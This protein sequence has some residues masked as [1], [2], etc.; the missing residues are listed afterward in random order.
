MGRRANPPEPTSS[1]VEPWAVSRCRTRAVEVVA[2]GERTDGGAAGAALRAKRMRLVY[3]AAIAA[4]LIALGFTTERWVRRRHR[5]SVT[6]QLSQALSTYAE[7]ALGLPLAPGE[8][9]AA[10]L[11]RIEAGLPEPAIGPAPMATEDAWPLR[12]RVDLDR[13]HALIS[14][15]PRFAREPAAARLDTLI[16]RARLDPMPT[17]AVDLLDTLLGAAPLAGAPMTPRLYPPPGPHLAPPPASPLG[18]AA[19]SPLPVR[20]RSA[21][22]EIPAID[23]LTL[24]LSFFDP[25]EVP[26]TCAFTP[27]HGDPMRAARCD[28]ARP[29]ALSAG[30]EDETRRPGVLRTARGRFDRFELLR[31]VPGAA[32]DITSLTLSAETV[33]IYGDQLIWVTAHR[34]YA[35]K[36]TP[37]RAPLGPPID[38]GEVVGASPELEACQTAT[39]LVVGVRTFDDTL[40]EHKGWRSMAA[41]ERTAGD[42]KRTPGR[43]AVDVGATFTC[44]G[45]AGVWTWFDRKV[46]SQVRCNADR[47]EP[48]ASDRMTLAWD[49]GGPLYAADLGGR[50]LVLG[51]GT[52]PG[53]VTGKSVAS[54]RM[55]MAP[56]S[57][58]ATASDVVLFSDAAHDGASVSNV[59][60][61]VR[62]GV[63]LVLLRGDP[64]LSYRAI[65]L[66]ALGRFEPITLA[67]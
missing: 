67:E 43:F 8:T 42:W 40:P 25:K 34:W 15:D 4:V 49:V 17:D 31:S 57:A 19:L 2:A 48:R 62:D 64:P 53:P 55:R 58:I 10:R 20:I 63:A 45:H 26:W 18:A 11:R 22:D 60:V 14:G 44:Q 56:L 36:V 47:C 32:P 51:L 23:P 29:G 5:R 13:A 21:P 1:K 37:G 7:C 52:T 9:A 59:A 39:A 65:R 66:D 50:A 24:R 38:L 41:H 3:G 28:E 61:F 35:R 46:V 6:E 12:C 54:V 27:L 33:A 16:Q 30:R